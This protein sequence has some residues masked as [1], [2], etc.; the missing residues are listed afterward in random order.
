MSLS[1]RL[2]SLIDREESFREYWST[3]HAVSFMLASGEN[4]FGPEDPLV[5]GMIEHLRHMGYSD[6]MYVDLPDFIP[7]DQ[8]HLFRYGVPLSGC[9]KIKSNV[10]NPSIAI[11]ELGQDGSIRDSVIIQYHPTAMRTRAYTVI[12]SAYF[13]NPSPLHDV[14]RAFL[15]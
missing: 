12:M 2:I 6:A 7:V 13:E 15:E 10:K 9:V 14:T 1:D 3:A 5:T 4:E 8:E 11:P